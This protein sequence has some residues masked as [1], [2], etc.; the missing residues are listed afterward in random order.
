MSFSFVL[1][2]VRLV[3]FCGVLL[4]G[5]MGLA[6]IPGLSEALDRT[7]VQGTVIDVPGPPSSLRDCARSGE[8]ISVADAKPLME[9]R[10][11]SGSVYA[12]V[13]PN[14]QTVQNPS[15]SLAQIRS[16]VQQAY[17]QHVMSRVSTPAVTSID[18]QYLTL[19]YPANYYGN[20]EPITVRV[21]RLALQ[22]P[23]RTLVAYFAN[24]DRVEPARKEIIFHVN[25]HFGQNPSRLG[26]GLEQNGGY[27][28][29]ATAKIAMQYLPLITYDDHNVGESSP[30]PDSLPRTLENLQMMDRTLLVHFDRVDGIGLSGGTERL[31]H[32]MC[33]FEC[34]MAS[35]YYG[36]WAVPGWTALDSALAPDSPFGRNMDTYDEEFLRYFQHA[37]L[38][39]VGMGRGVRT[40]YSH[41]QREGGSSKYGLWEEQVPTQRQYVV[42]AFENGGDDPDCNGIS[43]D[44]RNLCHEYDLPHF[45]DWLRRGRL[46]NRSRVVGVGVDP[47]NDEPWVAGRLDVT[48]D[49]VGDRWQMTRY[50]TSGAEAVGFNP[51][52]PGKY[53]DMVGGGGVSLDPAGQPWL[54][55][56]YD[57]D[58]DGIADRFQA[59]RFSPAT[60]ASTAGFTLND[61]P[62]YRVSRAAGLDAGHT[63]N[64][65]WFIGELGGGSY[66]SR[67]QAAKFNPATG[68]AA[69]GFL[70]DAAFSSAEGI[71]G[72]DP[73]GGGSPN[74]LLIVGPTGLA[75]YSIYRLNAATG[76]V[77]SSFQL[78]AGFLDGRGVGL[79]P[80]TGQCWIVGPF[81]S[82]QDGARD[83]FTARR[84]DAATGSQAMSLSLE[85]GIVDASGVGVDG[86]GRPWLLVLVDQDGDGAGD[87][88]ALRRY[89]PSTGQADAAFPIDARYV[90]PK[91]SPVAVRPPADLD[92]DGDVDGTDVL[93][94]A[95]CLSG[96]GIPPV[97]DCANRDFDQDSDVDQTDFSVLQQCLSGAFILADPGCTQ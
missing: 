59:D 64:F 5:E 41:N 40:A 3:L 92:G 24:Y 66:P 34:R 54:C 17:N 55:G 51:D 50:A 18:V 6:Q 30:A 91:L 44:G 29:A 39:L 82:N 20:P 83:E 88:W 53:V 61:V 97:P 74:E 46:G 60:G 9:S 21:K 85:T 16:L 90:V 81:D 14:W 42:D 37:D 22:A 11:G 28:G 58:G 12:S 10:K 80:G 36:G 62:F 77:F 4:S 47:A 49:G 33:F 84:Y 78:P 7:M 71:G 23:G 45:F 75:R 19:V 70:F 95:S 57:A 1:Y 27:S 86:S 15:V 38:T 13:R 73:P 32:F 76:A 35:V 65:P 56:S 31:Y 72:R 67:K 68:V 26:L 93:L 63:P 8:A 79:D 43:N 89:N 52:P 96:A 87:R 69:L 25:G 2:R 48:G 94:F